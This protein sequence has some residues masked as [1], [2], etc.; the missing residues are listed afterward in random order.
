[1]NGISRTRAEPRTLV[2]A[3]R[4]AEGGAEDWAELEGR[5]GMEKPQLLVCR[6]GSCLLPALTVEEAK[7]RL[8][9]I[10]EGR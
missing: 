10:G 9:G 1:M 6:E 7:E 2:A 3:D 8:E 4:A 5:I